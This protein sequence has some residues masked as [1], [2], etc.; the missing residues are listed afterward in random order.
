[1]A[2][3]KDTARGRGRQ[4]HP[5]STSSHELD[6]LKALTATLKRSSTCSSTCSCHTIKD[7]AAPFK[8]AQ[9][10][11]PTDSQSLLSSIHI[12]GSLA[13]VLM[14]GQHS[15]EAQHEAVE[16]LERYGPC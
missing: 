7:I 2:P 3:K 10:E 14:E 11:R 13:A 6:A 15:F 12:M 4:Q 9:Q 8:A 1:M 16:L 5:G